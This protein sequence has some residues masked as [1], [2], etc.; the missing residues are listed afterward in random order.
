MSEIKKV[1]VPLAADLLHDGHINI[2]YEAS[3]LDK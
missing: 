2:L 1:Y 3:K